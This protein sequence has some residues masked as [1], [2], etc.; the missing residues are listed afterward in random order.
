M[1]REPAEEALITV[2]LKQS[3]IIAFQHMTLYYLNYL[4]MTPEARPEQQ[5]L[6]EKL[7][8]MQTRIME[9]LFHE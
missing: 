7:T 5:Y 9:A 4:R 3:E 8:N 2:R 6:T 1:K